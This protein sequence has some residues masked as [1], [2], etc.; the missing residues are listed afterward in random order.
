MGCYYLIA[1][2]RSSFQFQYGETCYKFIPSWI[3][4][5]LRVEVTVANDL[6]VH[7]LLFDVIRLHYDEVGVPF[8]TV[9]C[10]QSGQ[11]SLF[12]FTKRLVDCVC[13][14]KMIYIY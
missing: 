1:M 11:S 14:E 6:C 13:D 9:G 7:R 3:H 12:L 5:K 8:L 10:F 4:E 2:T